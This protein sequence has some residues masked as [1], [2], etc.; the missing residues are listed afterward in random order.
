MSHILSSIEI[1]YREYYIKK[2]I[3]KIES[4]QYQ[5]ILHYDESMHLKNIECIAKVSSYQANIIINVFT[6]FICCVFTF[7]FLFILNLYI[8]LFPLHCLKKIRL[9]ILI[10]L[11]NN[12]NT[13]ISN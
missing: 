9:G 1:K 12:L 10:Y 6:N 5:Q 3:K 11:I 2:Y 7:L 8:F 4:I 13:H